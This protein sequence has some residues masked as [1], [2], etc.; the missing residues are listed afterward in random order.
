MKTIT[1]TD[2]Q[3]KELA[4]GGSITIQAPKKEWKPKGGEWYIDMHGDIFNS[5]MVIQKGRD[6]GTKYQTKEQAEWARD[7]M[8]AYNR[9]LAWLAENDDGWRAD[10]SKSTT[11]TQC[12]Y[13]ISFYR[14]N[15]VV[16]YSSDITELSIIYMSETNAEKLAK[17][18][19]SGE[20]VL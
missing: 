6:F 7:K 14:G 17:L 16:N 15:Y 20:V 2:E 5:V 1:L 3:A 9:Q 19:N 8:R 11:Q 13:Y 18:L 10:W 12:K 4:N